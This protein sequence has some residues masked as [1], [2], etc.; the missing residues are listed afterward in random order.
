MYC[1]RKIMMPELLCSTFCIN[2][3]NRKNNASNTNVLFLQNIKDT[4]PK[5]PSQLTK[6]Q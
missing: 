3:T 6:Q 1:I 2:G 4:K 5:Q